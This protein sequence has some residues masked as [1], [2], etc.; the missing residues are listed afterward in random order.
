M[1]WTNDQLNAINAR[2]S[3][4]LVSAAAG[5]GKTAVLVERILRRVMDKDNPVDIDSIMI[6]TFT[7]AA[8]AEMKSRLMNAFS[9]AL[10]NEPGNRHLIRQLALVENAK[11]S[12]IDSFCYDV[13]K[14]YYNTID[15]DP[16]I[17][18][19]DVGELSLIMEDVLGEILEE[20]F[21]AA[22]KE[23][24]DFVEAFAPGKSINRLSELIFSLFRFSQSNPW[25]I[26]W[27]LECLRQYEV[28][29]VD[30]LE[31]LPITKYIAEHIRA[32]CRENMKDCKYLLECCEEADG[33]LEYIPVIN[34]DLKLW[35]RASKGESYFDVLKALEGDFSKLPRSKATNKE[36]KDEVQDIRNKYKDSK[37]KLLKE[38]SSNAE[39]ELNEMKLTAP[40]VKVLVEL[41]I[42]F[43]NR[44]LSAK[45]AKNIG[46]FA[47]IEHYALDI[48]VSNE[49]GVLKYSQVADELSENFVELYIDEYQDSNLVQE[50]LLNAVSRERFGT[51]NIFMV[52][53]VKQSIYKFR[54]ARPE[55][56][57]EKYNSYKSFDNEKRTPY[58]KIELHKNFR[59]R[60]TVLESIND[61]FFKAMQESIGGIEYT[62]EVR[63]N[64]GGTFNTE[65]D[66]KTE[67]ILFDKNE[68]KDLD[69]S[70]A[71]LA[72]HIA[73]KR[74]EEILKEHEGLSY[75]DFAILLRSDKTSGPIYANVLASHGIPCVYNST[76]GYFSSY[77]V[78][79]VLDL[80]NIIDN[81]RQEIPL[82]G[83]M[84]SYFA[85]F[86]I[87]ELALIK[88][89]R[90][91][92]ELYDC[93][94]QYAAKD[95]PLSD[96]CKKF[97]KFLNSYREMVGVYSIRDILS[98]II[99]D[100]GYYDYIC[101]IPGGSL[102]KMNL[103]MLVEK[104]SSYE[105]TSYLG[106]FNFLRY[107]EK[108]QKY[109]VDYGEGGAA[110]SEINQVR[111]MSIHKSKGLEFP[112][113]ILGDLGKKYNLRDTS[114]EI[115][116][117][118]TYGIGMDYVDLMHRTKVKTGYKGMIGRKLTIDA[119]GEELRVLY[120]AMTR[121]VNK[122]I[123]IGKET[124]EKSMAV[125]ERISHN[126]RL[127][128][129]YLMSNTRY[130]AVI[131]PCAIN[132]PR[133]DVRIASANYLLDLMSEAFIEQSKI[134]EE[135]LHDIEEVD[136]DEEL[137]S[138]IENTLEY[139]YPY[140][141]ILALKSKYS[142]S[143]L[144][145]QAMEES[146]ALEEE[147]KLSPPERLIPKFISEETKEVGGVIRGNAYHKV[148]E[149]LDYSVEATV[150][151]IKAFLTEMVEK[152]RL[153]KEYSDLIKPDKFVKFLNSP[154]GE[155]MKNAF[156]EG[157]LY[158]EQPFIMEV[159]AN[160]IDKVYPEEEKVLIQGIVDAFFIKENG[161]H[162]VDYKTD[163]VPFDKGEEILIERYRTQ[164]ILYKE[165]LNKILPQKV[166]RI[167]IYSVALN[168][169]VEII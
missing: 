69:D 82:A 59:S 157:K 14:N 165:A 139:R 95:N 116:Y 93:L 92:T 110:K 48:L 65:W 121:A 140:F 101:A 149:I 160:L 147:F 60:E 114:S 74:I 132:N 41:T 29:T 79:N 80:L 50:Y 54:M 73:A 4:L 142:V 127:D 96:K 75:K 111:I 168:K 162:I 68:V 136:V 83:V 145:H 57:M 138:V 55:L 52:G 16:N 64:A 163:A 134:V 130:S 47:D 115:I 51:P 158:R 34:E 166:S 133:F 146:E 62:D 118:N 7:N 141:N 28:T 109:D 148:F 63:L 169:E 102:K 137:Y 164:L 67:L 117:D 1:A 107:I 78:V 161:V 106:L 56:F 88:G 81:P 152:G 33:P 143:D 30:E 71:E 91:K 32:L 77:E 2:N 123:L 46:D 27:L 70:N 150:E 125:W 84:R 120:V 58:E 119:I 5:S 129:N 18:I 156:F 154:L 43:S 37:K 6:V 11:I 105:K 94:I 40:F 31:A 15:L 103:D 124:V 89:K 144:K 72:A 113:V 21:E 35:E 13:V 9:N 66:D 100:T 86:D 151:G 128:V 39:A 104:A 90:R 25:P 17:R 53:D 19:A 36:L 22:D 45:Q 85:Y 61:V 99:Y 38:F 23:F 44:Y 10:K 24:I 131:A 49:D 112:V 12:T 26:R 153:S 8:A 108:L 97:L 3:N 155:D 87:E 42:D 122:L 126:D 135:K 159:S 76:T 167:S 20:R 98:N